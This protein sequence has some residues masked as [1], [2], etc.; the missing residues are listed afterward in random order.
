MNQ[1]KGNIDSREACNREIGMKKDLEEELSCAL[2]EIE[3][4][5]EKNRKQKNELEKYEDEII[6]AQNSSLR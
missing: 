3:R 6:E 1:K 5:K 4:F 2:E